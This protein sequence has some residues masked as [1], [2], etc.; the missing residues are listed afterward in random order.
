MQQSVRSDLWKIRLPFCSCSKAS[1]PRYTIIPLLSGFQWGSVSALPSY[2]TFFTFIWITRKWMFNSVRVSGSSL[3][4]LVFSTS[5][6]TVDVIQQ[7]TGMWHIMWKLW[8]VLMW[9]KI[10]LACSSSSNLFLKYSSFCGSPCQHTQE[11]SDWLLQVVWLSRGVQ[12][13][14]VSPDEVFQQW[15]HW[16]GLYNISQDLIV[17]EVLSRSTLIQTVKDE[18][19]LEKSCF[20]SFRKE[21]M[22]KCDQ[23]ELF[24]PQHIQLSESEWKCEPYI[25]VGFV[26]P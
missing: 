4:S 15:I 9:D 23:A 18:H 21:V 10:L 5:S 13:E 19:N 16:G 17:V 7:K 26:F 14:A 22:N 12:R 24:L 3:P 6:R 20:F 1:F 8:D 2:L 25:L 11:G